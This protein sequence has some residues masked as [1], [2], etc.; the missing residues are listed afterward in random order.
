MT[1]LAGMI[2]MRPLYAKGARRPFDTWG[3]IFLAMALIAGLTASIRI[4][5]W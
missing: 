1:L 3:Y 5:V 2:I 4:S